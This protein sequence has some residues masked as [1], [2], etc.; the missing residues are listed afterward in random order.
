MTI[1]WGYGTPEDPSNKKGQLLVDPDLQVAWVSRCWLA[2]SRKDMIG[3]ETPMNSYE[4]FRKTLLRK[5]L[6]F[7]VVAFQFS[8][9]HHQFYKLGCSPKPQKRDTKGWPK[10]WRENL[11][12]TE[13]VV[14]N[15]PLSGSEWKHHGKHRGNASYGVFQTASVLKNCDGNHLLPKQSSRRFLLER[16]AVDP[17]YFSRKNLFVLRDV[18]QIEYWIL[19]KVTK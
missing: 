7:V 3:L 19:G 9:A 10:L 4:E 18:W 1:G 6:Y 14:S 8:L 5:I 17:G 2:Q 16:Y 13:W 11:W 12:G 15:V